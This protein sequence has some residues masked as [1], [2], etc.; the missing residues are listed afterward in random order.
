MTCGI[1]KWLSFMANALALYLNVKFSL[2]V[3]AVLAESIQPAMSTLKDPSLKV[4]PGERRPKWRDCTLI[5]K[6]VSSC[7]NKQGMSQ[8]ESTSSW[9]TGYDYYSWKAA[10]KFPHTHYSRDE[11]YWG[12]EMQ[13][14]MSAVQHQWCILLR[15]VD[16]N[17]A[18][19]VSRAGTGKNLLS[20]ESTPCLPG[21]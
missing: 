7:T 4:P 5:W 20:C 2:P 15:R 10:C 9:L 6:A 17:G 19:S 11:D 1:V 18:N 21:V 13:R 16:D 8:N 3:T 12:S 14:Q